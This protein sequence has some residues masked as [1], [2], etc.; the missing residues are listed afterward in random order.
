MHGERTGMRRLKTAL[1]SKYRYRG[2]EIKI[3]T[4]RNLEDLTLDFPVAHIAKVRAHVHIM[5]TKLFTL[6]RQVVGTLATSPPKP[7]EDVSGLLVIK[8]YSYTILDPRELKDFADLSTCMITQRQRIMLGVGWDLVKWHLQG[9]YGEISEGLDKDGSPTVRVGYEL[10]A[11]DCTN[12]AVLTQVMGA[13]DVKLTQEHVL[14][15]EWNSSAG[16][17]MIADA[18]LSLIMEI[19][20]S[21]ASVKCE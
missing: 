21:P 5:V 1:E 12:S 4:P 11:Q 6:Q 18:C 8:D 9:M 13:V 3:H 20:K 2:E 15:L 19:D 17:D 7:G 16:N 14:T 10:G